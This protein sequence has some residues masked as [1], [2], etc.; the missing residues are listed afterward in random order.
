MR[1]N[2]EIDA[3]EAAALAPS[4][5]VIS[6]G[7]GRPA[8]AAATG[9]I[10][11]RLLPTTPTLGVCLGHQA[12]VEVCGGEVGY[13]RE[14]VHGKASPVRHNGAGLFTG[15]PDPFDAGRYHSLAATQLPD[16]L[17]PTAFADDGE[18]MARA[19]PRVPGRRRPVPS[20]VGAHARRPRAR[21]QLPRRASLVPF[22]AVDPAS[23]V[24][25]TRP[26]TD[27]EP[28]RHV[29]ELSEALE[30]EH[31]RANIWRYEPGAAGVG[32]CTPS[33]RRCSSC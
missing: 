14:L 13:A 9:A 28:A 12:L 22:R 27:G 32:T 29:A 4:H 5:L 31:L 2:D 26:H 33:R 25:E 20:R 19:A 10:L 16:V 21:A 15:L 24:W 6:P 30:T 11:E 18:V 3:D 17:E 23:L 8:D 1:R 7:P